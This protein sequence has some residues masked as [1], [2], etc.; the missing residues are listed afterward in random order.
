MSEPADSPYRFW[1]ASCLESFL[2]GGDPRAQAHPPPL[3]SARIFSWSW[4]A[5]PAPRHTPPTPSRRA[6][7]EQRPTHTTQ[8]GASCVGLCRHTRRSR[9]ARLDGGRTRPALRPA[10]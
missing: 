3:Q 6:D 7:A 10:A 1:L 2:R 5:T 8:P 9:E 4:A